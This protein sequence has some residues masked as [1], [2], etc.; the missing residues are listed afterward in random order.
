M[1]RIGSG[2]KKLKI[3]AKLGIVISLATL[4]GILVA[5]L[6]IFIYDDSVQKEILQAELL[7]LT[8]ITAQRSSA[9]VAFRDVR[10]AQ[11]NLKALQI[12]NI[13]GVACLYDSF[14]NLFTH[15]TKEDDELKALRLVKVEPDV[16]SKAGTIRNR[17]H[18]KVVD[19]P[20]LKQYDENHCPV[21]VRELGVYIDDHKVEAYAS[22]VQGSLNVG[23]L[24]V[25][26]SLNEIRSR[27][28]AFAKVGSLALC[29]SLFI[30]VMLIFPIKRQIAAP[31]LELGKVAKKVEHDKDYSVRATVKNQEDELGV[32]LFAFNNMLDTIEMNNVVLTKMAYYD[33][34]TGIG[35]RRLFMEKLQEEVSECQAL[36]TRLA[37]MFIDLD[38][39]KPINDNLGHDVG[40][41]LLETV[42]ERLQAAMPDQGAAYRLG[43][44]EFTVILTQIEGEQQVRQVAEEIL[45]QFAQKTILKEHPITITAS[46][47]IAITDGSETT[48]AL[49]KRADSILYDV[50][51]SGRNGFQISGVEQIGVV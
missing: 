9:A 50:K 40:D 41:M 8:Q 31:I 19:D 20:M 1:T 4:M 5:Y 15:V 3:T 7:V 26:A 25:S 37:L 30:T 23:H 48:G 33:A 16:L 29:I 36:Q 51:E 18:Q 34:L 27:Q 11:D 39:F 45:R 13:I 43:G 38:K 44:D 22:V 32:T 35:N 49:I 42:A 10:K 21:K 14:G 46:L 17:N 2:F 6:F 24:Y 47:G 28:Q 12:R